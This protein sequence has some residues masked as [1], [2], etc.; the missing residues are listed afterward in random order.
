MGRTRGILTYG[1][2]RKIWPYPY[3]PGQSEDELCIKIHIQDASDTLTSDNDWQHLPF[4]SR[5]THH[6]LCP[7]HTPLTTSNPLLVHSPLLLLMM[8]TRE[9]NIFTLLPFLHQVKKYVLKV[10]LVKVSFK[11]LGIQLQTS[12][13]KSMLAKS[14]KLNTYNPVGRS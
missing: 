5:E 13:E 2:D 7:S 4:P 11:T 3:I 14:Y 10:N 6:C 1:I 12:K 8:I 9:K